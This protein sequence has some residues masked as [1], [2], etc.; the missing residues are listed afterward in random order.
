VNAAAR[1]AQ[2]K[3]L[4]VVTED[5]YFCSH[6]LPLARAARDDGYEVLVAT[7]I[8]RHAEQIRGEG[9]RPIPLRLRRRRSNPWNEVASI[10]ELV[11]LY[12]RE[13]PDIVHHVAMKPVIYGSLAALLARVPF[14]V[15]ALAGFGYIFTSTQVRA[16]LLRRPVRA[17]L[18]KLLTAGE[19]RT[20][21]QNPDDARALRELGIPDARI[22]VIP[23]SGVDTQAFQPAPEPEGPVVV[24]MVARMLWDKGVGELV[25][26]ARLLKREL[27][28][29][30]IWLVGPPDAENPASIP[31]SQ[32]TRW[33]DEGILEWLGQHE[34]VAALWRQAHIAVLPSYREG[35]PKSLLEAAASGRPMV[36]ADVPGCREI[37][38]DNETGL[39]VPARDAVAL[40]GALSR[41]AGDA[42][43]RQ[44]MG[45]A[46]RHRAVEHFSQERIGSE[47]LALYRSLVPG[48]CAALAR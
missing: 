46:A 8:D 2:P 37:V 21:V 35:L 13:K 25:A 22:A 1:S 9:F 41:L 11:R 15:N 43:L 4:F 16:R 6:R 20:I 33:V 27:P 32:L 34:D 26:A 45:A 24:C 18:R 23:G 19:G 36:A 5:W 44:R 47:T 3:L 7:R 10:I 30:R 38:V 31:E 29:L 12:R 28:S 14:I 48:S 40:A 42:A 39:L 17:A